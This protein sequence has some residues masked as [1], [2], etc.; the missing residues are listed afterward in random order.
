MPVRLSTSPPRGVSGSF[1]SRRSGRSA[2]CFSAFLGY[3]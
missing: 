2:C 3:S 1:R